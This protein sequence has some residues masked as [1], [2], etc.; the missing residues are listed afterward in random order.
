MGSQQS[1]KRCKICSTLNKNKKSYLCEECQFIPNYITKFG[2][3]NLKRIIHSSFQ[4]YEK[5]I[6][7]NDDEEQH[8]IERSKSFKKKSNRL[9]LNEPLPSAP[10]APYNESEFMEHIGGG[11]CK[12]KQCSCQERSFR[13]PPSYPSY[14]T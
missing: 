5:P 14:H 7:I 4:D 11:G 8:I 1:K 9:T 12:S 6:D 3:E 2:R 10:S 13:P